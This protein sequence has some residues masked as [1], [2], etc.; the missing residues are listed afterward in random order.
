MAKQLAV[1]LAS[2]LFAIPCSIPRNRNGG[3]TK[4][5]RLRIDVRRGRR[6]IE[7]NDVVACVLV[8]SLEW[9]EREK[10]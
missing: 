2:L 6:E 4:M 8:H 7:E 5:H 3:E 9:R 1:S 10:E